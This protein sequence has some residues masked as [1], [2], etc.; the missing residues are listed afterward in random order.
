MCVD[1]ENAKFKNTLNSVIGEADKL[2]AERC[3]R[4]GK[5]ISVDKLRDYFKNAEEFAKNYTSIS[6][7]HAFS[8]SEL[9]KWFKKMIEQAGKEGI[10]VEASGRSD[11][12]TMGYCDELL[13]DLGDE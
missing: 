12:L 13:G 4:E 3:K 1:D 5:E 11:K 6:K 10:T 7:Q 9:V 2:Y 8:L